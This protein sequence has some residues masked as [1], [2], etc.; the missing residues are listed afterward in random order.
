MGFKGCTSFDFTF[1]FPF[2]IDCEY[3][4]KNFI[5]FIKCWDLFK[6]HLSFDMDADIKYS[7]LFEELK[8]FEV[9]LNLQ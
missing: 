1:A 9:I 4:E 3:G 2:K 6:V 5:I 7:Y 8:N